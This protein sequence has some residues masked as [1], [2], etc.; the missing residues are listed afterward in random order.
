MF[1]LSAYIPEMEATTSIVA[2]NQN[3]AF[4]GMNF[5][6]PLTLGKIKPDSHN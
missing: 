4:W 5:L 3:L 1:S 6:R 2:V